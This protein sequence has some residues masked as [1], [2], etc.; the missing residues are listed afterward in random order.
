MFCVFVQ[1]QS[2]SYAKADDDTTEACP[3]TGFD[4]GAIDWSIGDVLRAAAAET[5]AEGA[6]KLPIRRIWATLLAA[7]VLRG[8]DEH[9][10]L[11]AS[12]FGFVELC[13]DAPRP[14]CGAF[15]PS[16]P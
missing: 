16:S 7:A 10:L 12:L 13:G 15:L 5:E 1:N 14:P 4:H 2:K 11:Q 3:V 8:M 6:D 9:F